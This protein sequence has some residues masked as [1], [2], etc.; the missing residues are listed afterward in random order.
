MTEDEKYMSRC[1]QLARN[2]FYGAAPNPMVGAVIV[3]EGIIIGE[4]YH[5]CCG[6]PHAEV[7]AIRSVRC[8]DLLPEST[9]YV[10]LEPC[11]HYGKTPPCADLIIEKGFRRV[12]VGCKDPFPEVSGRGIRK[13]QEAGIDVTVGVLERECRE[14]NRRFIT[15]HTACRPVVT[16]KWAQSSDGFMDME[17]VDYKMERPYAFS[18]AYTRMLVHRCRAEH[19]AILV[20]KRT[21]LADN[22]SLT[23]RLWFGKSPLRLV[24]DCQGKLPESLSLFDGSVPTRVYM[25]KSTGRVPYE[26][27][28]GVECVRLDFSQNILP[29]IMKDLYRL[30]IQTL[31]VEGGSH[32]LKSFLAEGLWDEVRIEQ[33]PVRLGTGVPA[34]GKPDGQVEVEVC[35]GNQIIRIR[36]CKAV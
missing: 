14:L 32:L 33:S 2:G 34:P 18:T 21:A 28:Q 1:L 25:D 10:S 11:S 12:V 7:N 23:N 26:G 27:F 16:L 4:G 29:V 31:L 3:H 22:P 17:R 36:P 15:F 35:D 19:E 6:G 13:I 9:I 8:P 5:V 24:L 20:G 30:G